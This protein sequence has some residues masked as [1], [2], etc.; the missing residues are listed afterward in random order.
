MIKVCRVCNQEVDFGKSRATTCSGCI[1][2]GRKWCSKCGRVL[3][4]EDFSKSGQ[5]HMNICKM[6][7]NERNKQ[8]RHTPEGN[9]KANESLRRY[10][11]IQEVRQKH[12]LRNQ[13]H[14]SQGNLTSEQWQ[15]AC[16]AF[17]LS[18]AYCGKEDKL[19]M[20]HVTP[21]S[22]GGTTTLGNIIPACQSCNSSKGNRD[23][24][25]WYARQPFYSK[26]RLEN[27]IT[28]IKGVAPCQR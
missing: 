11:S 28:Y 21:I 20:D 7:H 17:A 23:L 18:C 26:Q 8:W 19:T 15:N 12:V 1:K 13:L 2:E 4:I 3:S 14:K 16:L 22:Q 9:R 24:I 5:G 25:E 27:I 6:C 10:R